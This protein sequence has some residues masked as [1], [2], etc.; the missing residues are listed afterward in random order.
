[1]ISTQYPTL[2]AHPSTPS[3]VTTGLTVRIIDECNMT[4]TAL[5]RPLLE[6]DTHLIEAGTSSL[7]VI[8]GNANVAKSATGLFVA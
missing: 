5:F 6:L 4:H 7:E 2:S 1:M 3:S 8:D